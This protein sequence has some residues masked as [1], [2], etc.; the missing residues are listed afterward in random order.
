MDSNIP[1]QSQTGKP[2]VAV[3]PVNYSITCSGNQFRLFCWILDWSNQP[4]SVKI[5]KRETVDELKE[6]IKKKKKPELDHLA[7]DTLVVWKVGKSYG[8]ASIGR[9]NVLESYPHPF[10]LRKST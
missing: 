7:A 5:G 8:R 3:R 2:S 10:L 6:A 1:N 9:S 4:F